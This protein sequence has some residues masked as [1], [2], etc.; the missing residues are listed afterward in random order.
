LVVKHK[1]LVDLKAEEECVHQSVG[2][3]ECL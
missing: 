3:L 1:R 2:V